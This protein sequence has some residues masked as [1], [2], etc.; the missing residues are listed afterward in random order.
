MCTKCFLNLSGRLVVLKPE[1]ALRLLSASEVAIFFVATTGA[2]A[3]VAYGT[4]TD[5]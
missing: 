3:V 5:K 4:T 1:N 2:L